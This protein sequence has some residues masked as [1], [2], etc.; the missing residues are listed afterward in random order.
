MK[1]MHTVTYTAHQ[2]TSIITLTDKANECNL[3]NGSLH[4]N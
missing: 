4:D 3:Y 2:M 1:N